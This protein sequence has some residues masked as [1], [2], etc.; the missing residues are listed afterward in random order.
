MLKAQASKY[1]PS[2][3][4]FEAESLA[5]MG[6]AG[7]LFSI[8]IRCFF[9]FGILVSCSTSNSKGCCTCQVMSFLVAACSART[10]SFFVLDND[11]WACTGLAQL[12]E[13]CGSVY[14][15]HQSPVNCI[16]LCESRL[17]LLYTVAH[18]RP[19]YTFENCSRASHQYLLYTHGTLTNWNQLALWCDAAALDTGANCAARRHNG[20]VVVLLLDGLLANPFKSPIALA[21]VKR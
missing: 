4:D 17:S 9:G 3:W 21:E 5:I 20:H 15:Q 11:S 14:V 8:G 2:H 10:F 13:H 7:L 16:S 12:T 18:A 6:R 19:H 1:K